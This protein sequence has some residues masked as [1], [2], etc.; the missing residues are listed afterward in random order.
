MTEAARQATGLT[1]PTWILA[2]SQTAARGRRG[3]VWKNTDGNFSATLVMYPSGGAAQAALRSFIAALALWD[4]LVLATGR[5]EILALKWPNDVL[6]NGSKV[7]GILLETTGQGG[8]M[9]PLSIGIGVNLVAAPEA[10]EVEAGALPPTSV[11]S[12]AGVRIG[13]EEFLDLLAPAFAQWE[14]RL[15]EGGFAGIRAAF[16]DRAARLGEVVTARTIRETYTGTFEGIDE[17]GA[18]VLVTARGRLSIP[19]ADIYF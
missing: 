12:G 15:A 6:M 17:T 16:L 9:S 4:A 14:V 8:Q 19:A 10:P 11:L 7:A 5:P 2:L 13:A 3:R 18:L 1:Q